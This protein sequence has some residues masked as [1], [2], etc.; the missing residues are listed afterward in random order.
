MVNLRT[1]FSSTQLKCKVSYIPSWNVAH[2]RDVVR[3]EVEVVRQ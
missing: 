3:L 2:D 1:T